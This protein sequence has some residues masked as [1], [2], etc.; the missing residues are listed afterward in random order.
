MIKLLFDSD[1]IVRNPIRNV[2]VIV[3]FLCKNFAMV[4][5]F[6]NNIKILTYE[7]AIYQPIMRSAIFFDNLINLNVKV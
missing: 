4:D 2:M 6:F 1:K 3:L 5:F 7:L